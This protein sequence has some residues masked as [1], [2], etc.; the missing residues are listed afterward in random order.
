M[1]A[2]PTKVNAKQ[3]RIVLYIVSALYL[4]AGIILITLVLVHDSHKSFP[5]TELALAIT[6]I[7]GSVTFFI[8]ARSRK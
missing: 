8:A 3:I 4:L 1:I 6:A 5:L 7:L 2:K